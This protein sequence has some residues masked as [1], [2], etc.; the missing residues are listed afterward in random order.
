M[1][2]L[3][4]S[5]LQQFF[6]LSHYR[7]YR[8]CNWDEKAIR[9]LIGDGKLASRQ[10]YTD[11]MQVVGQQQEQHECPICF[12][13]YRQMNVTKCCQA[14]ICT[15][16]YLQ[17]QPYQKQSRNPNNNEKP[18]IN[19]KTQQNSCPFCNTAK[20][21]VSVVPLKA[22]QLTEQEQQ[23]EQAVTTPVKVAPTD[24]DEQQPEMNPN[25]TT[26]TPT[27]PKT[28]FGSSLEQD[29]HVA[30]MRARSC[31]IASEHSHSSS[32]PS[33][34]EQQDIVSTIAATPE[35][36]QHLEDE[37]RAQHLHP[38]ALKIQ[39]EENDRRLKNELQYYSQRN[40]LLQQR[41]QQSAS[42]T[43]TTATSAAVAR[44]HPQ[45]NIPRRTLLSPQTYQRPSTTSDMLLLHPANRGNVGV[46][47][48]AAP[49]SSSVSAI[50]SVRGMS[51]EQQLALAIEASLRETMAS[52]SAAAP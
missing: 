47:G 18:V 24:Q 34:K 48:G 9:R 16:C 22:P 21:Q 6:F 30:M 33:I 5:I 7:L 27:T 2:D 11:E 4:F 15:E 42:T 46:I 28:G 32:T 20:L 43:A 3:S 8:S 12:F 10:Q 44:S 41:R 35:D 49:P 23:P 38:L 36:R 25:N 37:M 50:A 52:G 13:S 31:S 26:V 29:A 39:Q 40:L 45:Q 51:E 19:V 17:L 1:I 14:D